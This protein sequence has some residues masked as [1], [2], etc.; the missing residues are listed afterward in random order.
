[1]DVSRRKTWI[2]IATIILVALAIF[3]I[4]F[5]IAS[6]QAQQA[7]PGL[8]VPAGPAPSASYGI[9]D[10]AT[11]LDLSGI[12]RYLFMA[13]AGI[14]SLIAWLGGMLMDI[15]IGFFTVGMVEAVEKLGL[16]VAINEMWTVIRDIFNLLFI[17]GLIFAGFKIILGVDDSA[18]K[19]TVGMIVVAAL[20]I[21][22]SLYVSQVVVDFT[23]VAAYQIHQLINPGTAESK[24]G[25]LGIPINNVSNQ[26]YLITG[27]S[28]NRGEIDEELAPVSGGVDQF[29]KALVLG[30]VFLIFYTI[31]G[32]VFAACAIILFTRFFALVFLMIFSPLMFLGWV[33]PSLASLGSSWRK[34][35]LNQALVGPALLFMIYLSLRA[36]QGLGT[37]DKEGGLIATIVYLLIVVA[38]LFASLKVAKS[39]GAYGSAQAMSIG[40]SWGNSVRGMATGIAGRNTLGRLG[41]AY[42]RRLEE[43]GVSDKSWRRSI[44]SSVASKKYGGSYS[45]TDARASEEKASQKKARYEQLYGKRDERKIGYGVASISIPKGARKGGLT[46]LIQVGAVSN[47][48]SDERIAMEK[49]ISGAS[50]E[51]LIEMLGKHKPGSVEYENIVEHMSASQFESVMKAKADELDDN[52][53]DEIGKKRTEYVKAAVTAA[54]GI[55]KASDAQLKVLGSKEIADKAADI[56]QSQFDDI[57]KSKDYTETEKANIRTARETELINRFTTNPAGFFTGRKDKEVSKLPKVILTDPNAAPHLT[58][59]ALKQILNEDTLEP[60]E[61]A[62]IR[63][64]IANNGNP[65]ARTWLTTTPEGR[66]F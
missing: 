63:T 41:D 49:A 27:L 28:E 44:A 39:F 29:L 38:F 18:S 56:K 64:N 35:F 21:N 5:D 11:G 14:G 24:K 15:S 19:R 47:A 30:F 34:M 4:G 2:N 25:L 43:R 59:A 7:A 13:I 33:M 62:T 45:R 54:G 17:F 3:S 22:F 58:G 32:F 46:N 37:A 53:K 55:S 10:V 8:S 42:N 31:L 57:M 9:G 20:L 6:A 26:F 40:K 50:N 12:S 16:K 23:N 51:Q 65:T 36:L 52:A 61:R 48:G 60:N 1:M 66:L